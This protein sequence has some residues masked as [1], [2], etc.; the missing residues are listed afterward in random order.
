M[1]GVFLGAHASYAV[2]R[3]SRATI[4]ME[5]VARAYFSLMIEQS[6]SNLDAV[7]TPQFNEVQ[8]FLL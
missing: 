3:D 2:C 5:Q 1:V 6:N 4:N 7:L 8:G